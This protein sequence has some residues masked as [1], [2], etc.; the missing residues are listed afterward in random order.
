MKKYLQLFIVFILLLSMGSSFAYASSIQSLPD[1]DADTGGPRQ[2]EPGGPTPPPVATPTPTPSPRNPVHTPAPRP[3]ATDVFVINS[4]NIRNAMITIDGSIYFE[5]EYGDEALF[6]IE[7]G[8]YEITITG[9]NIL[10]HTETRNI[11]RDNNGNHIINMFYIELTFLVGLRIVDVSHIHDG[12]VVLFNEAGDYSASI[13]LDGRS[14]Y[15]VF[16][17]PGQHRI[18]ISGEYIAYI[19]NAPPSWM[20][21][22]VEGEP[23]INVSLLG[24]HLNN[25]IS[26]IIPPVP[27]PSD[28]TPQDIIDAVPAI[29]NVY[30]TP[31]T[32]GIST[33]TFVVIGAIVAVILVIVFR[34]YNKSRHNDTIVLLPGDFDENEVTL[35]ICLDSDK[36]DSFEDSYNDSLDA[37]F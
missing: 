13:E 24:V 3:T 26:V 16:V 37:T 35:A 25:S 18:E 11:V 20:I 1:N 15:H 30:P 14:I 17:E 23:F 27:S 28:E 12:R 36:N 31:S 22:I 33:T 4:Q 32:G 2:F 34:R 10:T 29:T 9:D 5:I 6:T 21:T 8:E 7:S 19:N